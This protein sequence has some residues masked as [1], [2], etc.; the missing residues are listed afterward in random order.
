M[1][2][3]RPGE[4]MGSRVRARLEELGWQQYQLLERI[5]DLD[6]G[7]LSA[8]INRDN[9]TSQWSDEIAEA[10]GVEH[11]WLQRGV[12]PK[13]RQVRDWPFRKV[14]PEQ[15]RGFPRPTGPNARATSCARWRRRRQP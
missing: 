3:K 2:R 11:R 12:E 4:H 13:L 1:K 15:W 8:L 9:L 7:T 6:S 14:T 10:L 5:P